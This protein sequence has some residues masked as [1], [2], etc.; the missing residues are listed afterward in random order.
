MAGWA[1]LVRKE[2]ARQAGVHPLWHHVAQGFS[3]GGLAELF[4][5]RFQQGFRGYQLALADETDRTARAIYEQLEKNPAVLNTLRTGKLALD[6]GSIVGAIAMGGI[7]LHDLLLVPLAASVTHQLV[8]LM[9]KSYV[10]AQRETTRTR[11]GVL[12]TQYI[13]NPLGEWLAQWPAT[14]GSAFERLQLALRRIPEA[15]RHLAQAVRAKS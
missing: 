4:K 2:A 3:G 1:D 15:V 8:E 11:Q 14:G 10:D 9:G 5:E 7:G 13:S 12:M 6:A